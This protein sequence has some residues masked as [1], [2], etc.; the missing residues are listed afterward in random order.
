MY[1][2]V[3]ANSIYRREGWVRLPNDKLSA[4]NEIVALKSVLTELKRF[5]SRVVSLPLIKKKLLKRRQG[6]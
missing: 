5:L 2:F 3:D 1:F 6:S 4:S